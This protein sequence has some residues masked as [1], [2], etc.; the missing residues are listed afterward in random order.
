[1]YDHRLLF[2]LS[3]FIDNEMIVAPSCGHRA[4]LEDMEN[5][6]LDLE[7][8]FKCKVCGQEDDEVDELLKDVTFWVDLLT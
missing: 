1:M 5:H 7:K 8:S 3:G 4:S 2:S 6:I